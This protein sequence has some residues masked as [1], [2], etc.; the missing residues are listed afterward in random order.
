MGLVDSR[1]S[2]PPNGP[3]NDPTA[4]HCRRPVRSVP[5]AP[6]PPRTRRCARCDRGGGRWPSRS[7]RAGY[8]S[9]RFD[10][11]RHDL[12]ESAPSVDGQARRAG[13]HDL[14]LC[15]GID[16][17]RL[18]LGKYCGM[19]TMPWEWRPIALAATRCSTTI[20]ACPAARRTLEQRPPE[21]QT[22]AARTEMLCLA[23]RS[24]A[25][26]SA[27]SVSRRPPVSMAAPAAP[28]KD[29]GPAPS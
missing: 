4:G 14:G 19:R 28:S 12:T 8:R 21:R 22:S 6:G 26:K 25:S 27:R 2:R 23:D 15:A 1:P 7:G 3:P 20:R 10:H 17:A 24:Q 18:D 13:L 29:C 5:P 9:Q 11:A 16:D